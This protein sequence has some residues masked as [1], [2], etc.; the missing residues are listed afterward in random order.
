MGEYFVLREKIQAM[1]RRTLVPKGS[2]STYSS[3]A[4]SKWLTLSVHAR[5]GVNL[6]VQRLTVLSD[7]F[8]DGNRATS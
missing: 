6:P 3:G 5:A 8:S 7:P 2:G 4:C 1:N